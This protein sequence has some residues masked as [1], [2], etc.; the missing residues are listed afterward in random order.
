M[1]TKG[2]ALQI[3]FCSGNKHRPAGA[4]VQNH[5][6]PHITDTIKFL[7]KHVIGGWPMS[8]PFLSTLAPKPNISHFMVFQWAMCIDT[9][10]LTDVQYMAGLCWNHF[11]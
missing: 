10:W 11:N 6:L 2:F 3:Q 5:S 9:M 7:I 8:V 1:H 4:T